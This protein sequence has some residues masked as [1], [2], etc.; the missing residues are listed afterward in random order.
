MSYLP[1]ALVRQSSGCRSL[2][3]RQRFLGEL[4]KPLENAKGHSGLPIVPFQTLPQAVRANIA[5]SALPFWKLRLGMSPV[6]VKRIYR[7]LEASHNEDDFHY[8]GRITPE[9]ERGDPVDMPLVTLDF[10]DNKLI[11]IEMVFGG[12]DW[13]SLDEFATAVTNPLGFPP[14]SLWTRSTKPVNWQVLTTDCADFTATI[15]FSPAQYKYESQ[16][17]LSDAAAARALM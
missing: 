16:G 4:R 2:I 6:E 15:R 17:K 13:Q 7:Q 12:L 1:Q 11:R 3:S 9:D 5:A 14:P 8:P 10:L